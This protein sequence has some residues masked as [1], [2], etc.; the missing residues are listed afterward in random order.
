M[1]RDLATLQYTLFHIYVNFELVTRSVFAKLVQ[2]LLL[3]AFS[4]E[5]NRNDH[6]ICNLKN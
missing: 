1:F 2:Q 6:M 3:S 4:E 5:E